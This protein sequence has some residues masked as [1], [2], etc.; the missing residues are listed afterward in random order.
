MP[1]PLS[2]K[3]RRTDEN[4][5]KSDAAGFLKLCRSKSPPVA[6]DSAS[7]LT[8]SRVPKTPKP[9]YRISVFCAN[10]PQMMTRYPPHSSLIDV[11]KIDSVPPELRRSKKLRKQGR[12]PTDRAA[13]ELSGLQLEFVAKFHTHTHSPSP[14][15]ERGHSLAVGGG[16][17][18]VPGKGRHG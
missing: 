7:S 4:D 11:D 5:K 15:T 6:G 10:Q 8:Q 17:R 1:S 2:Y 14:E 3:S 18:C 9:V 12:S 13:D 16:S